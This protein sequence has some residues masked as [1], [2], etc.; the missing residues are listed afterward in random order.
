MQADHRLLDAA[1]WQVA[2]ATRTLARLGD[3]PGEVLA[4][5]LP[6]GAARITGRTGAD[7]RRLQTGLSHHYY[8]IF[9]IGAALAILMLIFGKL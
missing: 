4:D 8:A 2:T 6:E 9:G 1:V 5:G 3:H 7:A